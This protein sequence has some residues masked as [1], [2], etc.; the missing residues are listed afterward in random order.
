MAT[1]DSLKRA[2][3]QK[4]PGTAKQRLSDAQYSA[5]FDLLVR[6]SAT[7]QDFVIPQLSQ[8]LTP[9]FN[10]RTEI[11]VLEIGPG[12]KSVLGFLPGRMKWKIWK[13]DAYEPNFLFA[14]SLEEWLCPLAKKESPLPGL[15]NTPDIRRI[16]FV[17]DSRAEHNGGPGVSDESGK[18]DLILFCHSMYGMKPHHMFVNQAL[19]LLD[20]R[21]EGGLVVVCHRHGTLDLTGLVCHRTISFPTGVIRIPNN[22]TS[23]ESFSSFIA[24]FVMHDLDADKDIR[25][26]WR[27]VCRTLGHVEEA[28]PE[29]LLFSAPEIMVAFTKHATTLGELTALVPLAKGSRAV[30]NREARFHRPAS[31]IRPTDVEHIQHCV[32]WAL[33]HRTGLTILGGGHS[34]HCLWPS[35]VSIDMD[36]FDQVHIIQA[37]EGEGDRASSLSS[38]SLVVVEAGCK[39][40]DIVRKTME[41]GLSIPLGARPSVGA[42]LWLQGGIGH[43]ARLEGLACDA[44]LGAVVVSVNS[45]QI[46][47]V[48][49]VPSQHQP[50]NAVRPDNESELLWALKGA[51]TNFGIVVSV[52][53]KASVALNYLTR[54][55]VFSLSDRLSAQRKLNDFDELVAGELPRNCSADAYLYCDADQLRFGVTTFESS[56]NHLSLA[57]V[58]P[59]AILNLG[60]E[61]NAKSVDS[62]GLFETEMYMS[63]MHGG[64]GGGKTSSFKRCLFLNGIGTESIA[65]LLVT[66]VEARP[67]S[68]CYIH[69]LH[70]GGAVRDVAPDTT[71][72]GCRDWTFACVITGVWHRSDDGTQIVQATIKWVYDVAMALLPLSTGAYGADL[73]PDPR[74]IPLAA[75]AFGPNL[76]RLAHIKSKLDSQRVMSYACPL[77]NAPMGPKLI[78]LL[79]GESCVGKDYCAPHVASVFDN[80]NRTTISLTSRV[81]SI[82]EETKRAYAVDVG[83]DLGRLLH[84]RPYKEQHRPALTAFFRR[85]VQKRPKLQEEHFLNTVREAQSVD[86]LIITGMRE[87]A[88]VA[89]LSHLV[90]ASRILEVRIHAS[91]ET[92]RSRGGSQGSSQIGK[93]SKGKK[94]SNDDEWKSMTAVDYRP[95]LLFNNEATGDEAVKAFAEKNLLPFFHEDLHRLADMVRLVPDFPRQGIEFRHVLN[96]SQQPGGLALCTSLLRSHFVGDWSG[97]TAI[98]CCEAGGFI[99]APALATEV[100]VP[101]VLIREAGKLPPPTLSIVKSPSHISSSTSWDLEENRIEIGRD[102]ISKGG[103]VVMVDDVLATGKTLCAVLKLLVRAG[104]DIENITVMTVAEF[105]M[106]RGR[107]MLHMD[108]F[109]RVAIQSLLV[110]GGA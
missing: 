72:F 45:G 103:R 64:H 33:K 51:G 1:L 24:G 65:D 83:A 13:Y 79:T 2:L 88:P 42:G 97:V 95:S 66:A 94:D 108:G 101:L 75:K 107:E 19:N 84:D 49:N 15:G 22:S 31:I 90:P 23:I 52:T 41:A 43:L 60:Q 40:G 55:W 47:L 37:E 71:A 53:F 100:N 11:S 35:V 27:E 89:T 78:I 61:D 63:G 17:L 3:R 9:L 26:E 14:T 106:H 73:G 18:Y 70:G 76:Q 104:V 69:F 39:T 102:V 25:N 105:P 87:E 81:M 12:P 67:S 10:T 91:Q 46:L 96:I 59:T 5:G 36:A 28:G 34:G 68:L 109:G 82:S 85:Q 93:D 21:L 48:G 54:N 29:N 16:P 92:R 77:P 58:K 80:N 86:V 99:F 4:A 62:V 30:K 98:V 7:Y 32:Q 44:I 110:Y 8:I 50:A 57:A 6:G 38:C 20:Q 74:D 56:T